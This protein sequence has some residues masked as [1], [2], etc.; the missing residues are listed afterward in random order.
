MYFLG[1]KMWWQEIQENC[2]EYL[3]VQEFLD[4]WIVKIKKKHDKRLLV[5]LNSNW[6]LRKNSKKN[7]VRW[8]CTGLY[9]GYD[10]MYICDT[11]N[12]AVKEGQPSQDPEQVQQLWREG[13]G[14]G[15]VGLFEYER[16]CT[17]VLLCYVIVSLRN[18][19]C[20]GLL[21]NTP[22]WLSDNKHLNIFSLFNI[23]KN[24]F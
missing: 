20:A 10:C 23:F 1:R 4:R 5:G 13:W 22:T 6:H 19:W 17:N 21:W 18:P 11:N 15:T 24:L 7:L 9:N 14:Q 8:T 2:F 12:L 16:V 3:F